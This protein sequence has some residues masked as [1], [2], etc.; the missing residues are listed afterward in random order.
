MKIKTTLLGVLGISTVL[1]IITL[2]SSILL[3]SSIGSLQQT[4]ENE[5]DILNLKSELIVVSDQLTAN[6]RAYVNT[7]RDEFYTAYMKEVDET[8]TYNRVIGELEQLLPGN[9]IT[10]I[11]SVQAES[12]KLA[13]QEMDAFVELEAGNKAEAMDLVYNEAYF[14]A[15]DKINGHLA[16]FDAELSAWMDGEI[17]AVQKGGANKLICTAWLY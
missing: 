7:E 10:I 1:S 16:D 2:I 11:Q 17:A 12:G 4:Y 3:T 9:L 14:A 6:A 8:Q 15:K 13:Q 5:V